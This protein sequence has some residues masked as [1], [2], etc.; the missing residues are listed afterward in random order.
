[1]GINEIEYTDLARLN[2]E[3]FSDILLKLLKFESEK[4]NFKDV[5]ILVPSNINVADEGEDGRIS[6]DAT[7]GSPWIRNNFTIFQVKAYDIL[8]NKIFKEFFTKN[9]LKIQPAIEEV[10]DGGGEYVFFISKA[11]T[12]PLITMRIKAAHKAIVE[13]NKNHNKNYSINQVRLLEGNQIKDWVNEYLYV[14]SRIK[15]YLKSS[16]PEGLMTIEQLGKYEYLTTPEFV[17]SD[18]II[19]RKADILQELSDTRKSVRLLGH[20][21]VGKTRLVYEI[22]KNEGE[23]AKN[24]IYYDASN[25]APEFVGFVQKVVSQTRTIFII[26]NCSKEFHEKLQKEIDRSDSQCSLLTISSSVHESEDYY[27]CSGGVNLILYLAKE[28]EDVLPKIIRNLYGSQINDIELERIHTFTDNYPAMAIHLHKVRT[29]EGA[30]QVTKIIDDDQIDKILYGN[31]PP[32]QLDVRLNTSIIKALSIFEYFPS[33]DVL[34]NNSNSQDELITQINFIVEKIC[35]VEKRF[36]KEVCNYFIKQKILIRR[37]RYLTVSPTPLAIKLALEWWKGLPNDEIEEFFNDVAKQGLGVFLVNRLRY[38]DASPEVQS[39][40]ELIIGE[41]GVLG[42]MEILNTELGSRLFSSLVEVNPEASIK[43]LEKLFLHAPIHELT[44]VEEGRQFLIWSLQKL[45]FRKETFNRAAKILYRFAQAPN[46][47]LSTNPQVIFIQL[48]RPCIGGTEADLRARLEILNYAL[49]QDFVVHNEFLIEAITA[50]FEVQGVKRIFGSELQCTRILKDYKPNELEI[51][52]YWEEIIRILEKL[53]VSHDELRSCIEKEFYYQSPQIVSYGMIDLVISFI[54]FMESYGGKIPTSFFNSLWQI[55]TSEEISETTKIG[56]KSFLGSR[57]PKTEKEIFI[58]LIRDGDYSLVEDQGSDNFEQTRNKVK[59]IAIRF[60]R[61]GYDIVELLDL[62][63]CGL[64]SYTEVFVTEYLSCRKQVKYNRQLWEL[65][66]DKLEKTELKERNWAVLQALLDNSKED[67]KLNLI[68]SLGE[69]EGFEKIFINLVNY[70]LM[71]VHELDE[72]WQL[73]ERKELNVE[74]IY[75]LRRGYFAY[76]DQFDA[77]RFVCEKFKFFGN[78]GYWYIIEIIA[79]RLVQTKK[80]GDEEWEYCRELFFQFDYF[81]FDNKPGIMSSFKVMEISIRLLD[82]FSDRALFIHIV[83]CLLRFLKTSRAADDM[84]HLRP[85]TKKMIEMDF[86]SFWVKLSDSLLTSEYMIFD[87]K[88]M[89]GSNLHYPG[90][91]HEG[92]LFSN[93]DNYGTMIEWCKQN[94]D[95]ALYIMAYLIPIYGSD[96]KSW[97]PFA[98]QMIDEFGDNIHFL[99]EMSAN[100]G[101]FRWNGSPI[102][103]Y[104]NQ[105]IMFKQL[106]L[107]LNPTVKEFARRQ[108]ED[109]EEYIKRQKIDEEERYLGQ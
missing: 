108:I 68:L 80:G 52:S 82:K 88:K 57:S 78:I 106:L 92:I 96:Q 10:L 37:G 40:I 97:H 41:L 23:F 107:H 100:M 42:K 1:M 67:E 95:E 30:Q 85:L 11:Y 69:I 19:N 54:K 50:A 7:N 39:Q 79:S 65:T 75:E 101:T 21:G 76:N 5:N 47:A 12:K 84:D 58:R 24:A 73:V 55:L 17:S 3:Q 103:Y 29:N 60:Y 27:I 38:L 59:E 70:N 93:P 72:V 13:I 105:I 6:C 14:V 8:P 26:D 45:C 94:S 15:E 102:G 104:E 22:F 87:I 98:K 74:I 18:W 66:V 109:V 90:K 61:D 49:S 86:K 56:I 2:P 91:Y 32:Q 64:Q 28:N 71:S 9:K 35:K 63:L 83:D 51:F 4:Y 33:F 77:A 81:N 62:M 48:F 36:F 99:H 53:W 44:N 34:K 20:S 31:S 46:I 89:I 25:A 43:T 16:P